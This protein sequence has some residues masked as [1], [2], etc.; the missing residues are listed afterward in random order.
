MKPGLVIYASAPVLDEG[1]TLRLDGKFVAG[2]AEHCALWPGPV[3]CLL[4]TG[5]TDIPFGA[6][7]H[8]PADLPFEPVLLAPDE[9]LGPQ[10]VAGAAAVFATADMAEALHLP[11]LARAAGA[12]L[13]YTLEYTIGTR[14]QI[15]RLDRSRSLPRRLWSAG[16]NL[17]QELRR[18]RAIR[19]ADGLQA[20]G[21][22]AYE[23][24]AGL[25]PRSMLYLDGRMTPDLLATEAE[26]AARRA[27]LVAGA[28]LR[29]IHSGR[30]EPLKG[31]QD[32]VP[33]MAALRAA[34]ASATLDVYGVG[35]LGESI[36]AEARAA[37]LGEALRLHGAVDFETELVPLTRAGADVFLSCHRQSDPSCTYVE[38]M[39]CGVTVAGYDN[40]MW[41]PMAAGAGAGAVA[42]LGDAAA[43]AAR[44]V[45]LDRDRAGL[46]AACERSLA[47]ARDHDFPTEFRRRMD[48]LKAIAL[49]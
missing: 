47:F 8:A 21:Y 31:A 33:V 30:L 10:H 40:R 14:L 6:A 46:A 48:H 38:A 24:Y 34:G 25:N 5:A 9:P 26:M 42:P 43:L 36:A 15:V 18:R 1:D 44:I 11:G 20:N 37:G 35:S 23:D 2:M 29:L 41:A 22:A 12:K 7:S 27:R 16:W 28:P 13:V 49:G 3:R 19:A 4:R 32:L 45:A 17:R 39:G